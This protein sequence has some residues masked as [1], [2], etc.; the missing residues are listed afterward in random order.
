VGEDPQIIPDEYSLVQEGMAFAI[1]PGAY[2]PGRFGARVENTYVV[3]R[4]GAELISGDC[5][6]S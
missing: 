6:G 5:T 2:W 3:R 4:A 1:E